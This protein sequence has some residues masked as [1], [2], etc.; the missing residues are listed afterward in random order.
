MPNFGSANFVGNWV[1]NVQAANVDGAG[2]FSPHDGVAT[3]EAKFGAG[4]VNV[5]LMGL[6]EFDGTIDGNTF[7]GTKATIPDTGDAAA[8][9]GMGAKFAGNF[10][11][12]FFGPLAAE[13]GGVF[14]FASDDD[15]DGKNE[16]GAFRGAFGADQKPPEE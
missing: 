16:G 2:A 15:K 11:G 10:S 3:M 7:S 13:A 6:A 5:M 9:L 8:M 1:A 12:A 14:D 4:T